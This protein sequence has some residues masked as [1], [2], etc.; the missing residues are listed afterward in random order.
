MIPSQV[1]I[2]RYEHAWSVPGE[3][4]DGV[5]LRQPGT[6][7][8]FWLICPATATLYF[9]RGKPEDLLDCQLGEECD[10]DIVHRNAAD[11]VAKIVAGENKKVCS[12][13]GEEK[14]L[15]EFRTY[16]VRVSDGGRQYARLCRPCENKRS[17][18]AASTREAQPGVSD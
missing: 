12:E 15:E 18:A 13:C 5:L 4:S 3:T 14:P 17:R 6:D 11:L 9:W 8:A 1:T 2:E 7:G 16:G 10:H